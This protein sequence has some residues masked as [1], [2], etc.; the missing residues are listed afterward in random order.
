MSPVLAILAGITL[1]VQVARASFLIH[2]GGLPNG[3]DVAACGSQIA[4]AHR[5]DVFRG[6]GFEGGVSTI[7]TIG[8]FS[9]H[10]D[11]DPRLLTQTRVEHLSNAIGQRADAVRAEAQRPSVDD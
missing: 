1:W 3:H 7:A 11:G 9:R 2:H 6:L 10:L 8:F 4:D 5:Q